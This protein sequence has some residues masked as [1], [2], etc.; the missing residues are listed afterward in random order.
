MQ[1]TNWYKLFYWLTVADNAKTFFIVGIVVFTLIAIVSTIINL[2]CGPGAEDNSNA[3]AKARKWIMWSYPFAILFWSLFIFTPSRK[4]ALFIVA[5][6]GTMTFL[7]SDS[8]AKQVPHELINFVTAELQG[9]AS[10][11]KVSLGINTQREKILDEAKGMT[12]EA[13]IDKMKSDTAFAKVIM[14]K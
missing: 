7:T 6:G 14:N 12:S 5:G 8:T 10:D 1:G 2:V 13:L 4:D 11:A 3:S 9:M